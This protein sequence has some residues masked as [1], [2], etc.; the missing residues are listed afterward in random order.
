MVSM[1]KGSEAMFDRRRRIIREA[2]KILSEEGPQGLN[3]RTLGKRANVSTRTIYNAFGSKETVIALAIHSYFEKFITG[4]RFDEDAYSFEGALIRQ[5]TSSSRDIDIPNYMLAIADLYFSHT[6]HPDIRA[7][8]YY[9]ATRPWIKWLKITEKSKQLEQGI[10]LNDLLSDISNIQ[11]ARI[12]EWT[13]GMMSDVEFL[14]KTL[15]S[16]LT[17]LAGATCGEA[18]D[19]VRRAMREVTGNTARWQELL[20]Q[21]R[22]CIDIAADQAPAKVSA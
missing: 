4:L 15:I 11:Y 20:S 6:L 3:I 8:L 14:R 10:D 12:N 17:T 16:V 9:F 7:V 13:S 19:D 21:A 2:R 5:V 22:K 18:H 1:V